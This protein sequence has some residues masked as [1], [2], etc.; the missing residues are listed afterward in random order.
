MGILLLTTLILLQQVSGSKYFIITRLMTALEAYTACI[1]NNSMLAVPQTEAEE[2]L[3]RTKNETGDFE[4]WTGEYVDEVAPW[5]Y[6]RG[7][8][9]A[10]DEALGL[11]NHTDNSGSLCLQTCGPNIGTVFVREDQCIC[12]WNDDAQEATKDFC[13][14]VCNGD[15]GTCGGQKV[16]YTQY[17]RCYEKQCPAE[18]NIGKNCVYIDLMGIRKAAPCEEQH[19]PVCVIGKGRDATIE[20]FV[21]ASDE[22]KKMSWKVSNKFCLRK[23]GVLADISEKT[24]VL[25]RIANELNITSSKP[26]FWIALNR[27]ITPPKSIT[28]TSSLSNS[29][30]CFYIAKGGNGTMYKNCEEKAFAS[31]RRK[32]DSTSPTDTVTSQTKN[33]SSSE[34][35]TS[36]VQVTGIS[37]GYIVLAVVVGASFIGII[38]GT[39]VLLKR[40][41]KSR[42]NN[43]SQSR[44][45]YDYTDVAEHQSSGI[46]LQ[47]QGSRPTGTSGSGSNTNSGHDIRNMDEENY[48]MMTNHSRPQQNSNATESNAYHSVAVGPEGDYNELRIGQIKVDVEMRDSFYATGQSLSAMEGNYDE[49]QKRDGHAETES[50][51]DHT[52]HLHD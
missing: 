17:S 12:N 28:G 36:N 30:Q 27:A 13:N 26:T 4:T 37:I 49:F 15:G 51:Y 44:P 1:E 24:Q 22:L 9:G 29:S 3:A 5:V 31:C 52:F 42:G 18:F 46:E 8:W 47:V 7:C 33:G 25:K 14:R 43:P 40:R 2:L 38:I 10:V 50:N 45:Q 35:S 21:N 19:F 39:S 34:D 16:Y 48:D 41:K 32:L 11:L 23:G 20:L 6:A